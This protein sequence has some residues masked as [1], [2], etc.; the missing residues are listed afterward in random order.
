LAP[1]DVLSMPIT[2]TTPEDLEVIRHSLQAKQDRQYAERDRL[3]ID[4]TTTNTV[5]EYQSRCASRLQGG[6]R[7][8]SLDQV[9]ANEDPTITAD[10]ERCHNVQPGGSASQQGQQP[11]PP[12]RR[13][14]QRPPSPT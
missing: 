7:A 12:L 13:N 3:R 2:A 11:N 4:L 8:R 9:I 14:Q 6:H 10:R 1:P 5:S